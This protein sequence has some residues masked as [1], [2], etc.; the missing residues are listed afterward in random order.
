MPCKGMDGQREIAV[1][2]T[3]GIQECEDAAEK[4]EIHEKSKQD[5]AYFCRSAPWKNQA[6]IHGDAAQLE[7]EIPPVVGS[8]MDQISKAEL[9]P[10]FAYKHQETT[11]KK[12]IFIFHAM[13]FHLCSFSKAPQCDPM[14]ITQ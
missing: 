12:E 6:D 14:L 8:V 3:G 13:F 5:A 2:H 1:I 7:G 9:F 4:T 11:V 10:Y